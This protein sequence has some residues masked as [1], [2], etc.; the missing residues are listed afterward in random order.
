MTNC[1]NCGAPVS[2]W[3]CDYCGAVFYDFSSLDISFDKQIFMRFKYE[4]K[5]VQTK[6]RLTNF[7]VNSQPDTVTLYAD[8]RPISYMTNVRTAIDMSFDVVDDIILRRD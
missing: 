2:G 1:P 8:C 3:Q 6:V 7:N 5:T 4:G